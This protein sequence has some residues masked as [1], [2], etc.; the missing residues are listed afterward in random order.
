MFYRNAQNLFF[1]TQQRYYAADAAKTE[2]NLNFSLPHGALFKNKAVKQVN[3]P[4]MSGEMG[5]LAQHV[6][7]ITEL[8]PGVVTVEDVEGN[9]SSYFISGGFAV[10]DD[11]SNC[12]V[13]AAE[14]FPTE[15][16]DTATAKSE[17]DRY[18]QMLKEAKTPDSTAEASIGVEVHSAMLT[19]AGAK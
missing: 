18:T 4:S 10:I 5:V 17:L 19:A 3:L 1:K 14:A 15:Q 7:V 6:P 9:R 12:N 16:I 2:L 11:E 13:S 8:Q